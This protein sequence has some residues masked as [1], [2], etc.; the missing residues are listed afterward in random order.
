M[1]IFLTYKLN[2]YNFLTYLTNLKL[3]KNFEK[4]IV[5]MQIYAHKEV[6]SVVV[7]FDNFIERKEILLSIYL[8]LCIKVYYYY[9]Y[10]Y[11]EY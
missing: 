7:T 11:Y 9:Y 10:Y 1:N 6:L 8:T 2:K 5:I 3:N 4:E